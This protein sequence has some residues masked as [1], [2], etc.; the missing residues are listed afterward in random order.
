MSQ[1]RTE[2][3]MHHLA[4]HLVACFLTRGDLWVS[5]ELGRDV[6]EKY[7]VDADW[8]I[9]N[10]S[11]HWL[12]CSAFFH[13]Y[14]RCYGPTTFFKKTDPEGAYIRKHLPI[15]NKY[16]DKYIYEPWMAPSHVQ[17]AAGCIVG[18]DYPGRIVDHA[19]VNKINMGKMKK[20][21]ADAKSSKSDDAP[22]EKK[23]KKK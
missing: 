13:Q 19:K 8:S 12:S 3:W 22:P 17:E 15:L 10:F 14:F 23:S 16:P 7:L 9:N 18:K 21:F 2:G 11:W 20:A 1:L 6:F 4:R 5:W